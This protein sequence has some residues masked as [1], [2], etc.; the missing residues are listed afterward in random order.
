VAPAAEL[1]LAELLA[2]LAKRSPAPGAGSAAAWSGALAA[3]LLEMAASFA[4]MRKAAERA[5]VLRA[6]LLDVGEAE[7]HAY[8]PA[9][10]AARLPASDP[11][12]AGQLDQALSHASEP[13]LA[14]VR[15]AA[16]VAELAASVADQSAPPVRGDAI[17][18]VVLAEAAARA[19]AQL[20]EINLGDRADD[21]RLAEVAR[22]SDR[23]AKARA[24]ALAGR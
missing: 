19:A 15:A 10:E 12:R 14:I 5:P 11:A 6:Q 16:E 23:A 20:V 17:A 4:Q 18:A 24:Q 2:A 21:P 13:P 7:L 8:E 3:A 9:L 1:P 22:L